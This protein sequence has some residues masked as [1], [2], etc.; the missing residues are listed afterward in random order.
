VLQTFKEGTEPTEY[1]PKPKSAK[2]GQ[3]FQ[4]DMDQGS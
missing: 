3:F 4:F 1:S 2:S